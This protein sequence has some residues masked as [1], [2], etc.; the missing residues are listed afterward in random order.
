MREGAGLRRWQ[1]MVV[2]QVQQQQDH[3]GW[4]GLCAE[5]LPEQAPRHRSGLVLLAAMQLLHFMAAAILFSQLLAV[6]PILPRHLALAV[7][8]HFRLELPLLHHLVAAFNL[9]APAAI[10]PNY[11]VAAES[12]LQTQDLALAAQLLRSSISLRRKQKKMVRS[13]SL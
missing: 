1:V 6:D 11:L 8:Q 4:G 2:M 3:G 5:D 9:L 7:L 10:L 12:L 13:S